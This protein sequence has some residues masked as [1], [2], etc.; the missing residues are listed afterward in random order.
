MSTRSFFI[1][2]ASIASAPVAVIESLNSKIAYVPKQKTRKRKQLPTST[3]TTLSS[4]SSSDTAVIDDSKH[5]SAVASLPTVIDTDEVLDDA[6][7]PL[8]ELLNDF[9]KKKEWAMQQ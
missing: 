8:V 3:S 1:V 2:L 7:E 9:P 4:T 6:N 5:A